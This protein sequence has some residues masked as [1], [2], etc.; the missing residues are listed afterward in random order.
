MALGL[1]LNVC[2]FEVEFNACAVIGI[3]CIG[4]RIEHTLELVLLIFSVGMRICPQKCVKFGVK[5]TLEIWRLELLT[6]RVRVCRP[7]CREA[8]F[9]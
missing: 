3:Y 6:L 1:S 9:A 8:V 5:N 7:V 4:A 2:H